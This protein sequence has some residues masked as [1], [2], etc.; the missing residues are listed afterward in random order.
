MLSTFAITRSMRKTYRM[1]G[2]LY[3][4]QRTPIIGKFLPDRIY[5]AEGLKIFAQI[6]STMGELLGIFFGKAIG[7]GVCVLYPYYKIAQCHSGQDTV[8]AML[9]F[10]AVGMFL[11]PC[12]FEGGKSDYYA[13][14]LMRMDA[15]KYTLSD[16]IF[17]LVKNFAGYM[18][19][20]LVV[21]LLVK[22]PLWIAL[23][24]PSFSVASKLATF[25]MWKLRFEY[26]NT[27]LEK[28]FLATRV[29]TTLGILAAWG[30]GIYLCE[31]PYVVSF[32]IMCVF[33]LGA[34][35][36]AFVAA[37]CNNYRH[38][39]QIVQEDL[40]AYAEEI[41]SETTT[42]N[43]RII[44]LEAGYKETNPEEKA[45]FT[46]LNRIFFRR[47]RKILWK[48]TLVISGVAIVASIGMGIGCMLNSEMASQTNDFLSNQLAYLV[49]VMYMTN[50]GKGIT[51]AMFVNCDRSLFPYTVYRKPENIWKLYKI[52]LCDLVKMNLV[53]GTTIALGIVAILYCSGGTPTY[54]YYGV[55]FVSIV[56]M[57]IF[58]SVHYLAIYYLLQP[59]TE[60]SKA[61]S[62]GYSV[63][64]WLTLFVVY[65]MVN[66]KMD[67]FIFGVA[68]I[69]FTLLYC[70]VT[71]VLI[72]KFAYKTFRIH[73][74]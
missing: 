50:R 12:V 4:I 60:E 70:L 71:G 47:H 30:F 54:W 2:I 27:R 36:G 15:K 62:L 9:C 46:Y 6:I 68:C 32:A 38:F 59:Y 69:A 34:I 10:M 17:K 44:K 31:V 14:F 64:N 13:I 43:S 7:I 29:I 58:F 39:Q 16:Y 65:L 26:D 19:V 35:W 55:A 20:C 57:S 74:G 56:M 49:F 8:F 33:Y 61:K 11:S 42:R 18:G 45:D 51:E 52:R 24:F 48:P 73:K 25:P 41:E 1:N 40:Q 22:A 63:V 28:V 67:A 21:A 5:A 23:A 53:S 66:V 3:A 72:K 37:K